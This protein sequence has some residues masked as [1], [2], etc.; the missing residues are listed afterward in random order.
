MATH[1]AT[2]E[3]PSKYRVVGMRPT[4]E[5][6]EISET[7]DL[8]AADKIMSVMWTTAQYS[9]IFIECNGKRLAP[10]RDN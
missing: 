5:R 1:Q 9:D 2:A 8:A 6:V 4:G 10:H 7:A 3:A